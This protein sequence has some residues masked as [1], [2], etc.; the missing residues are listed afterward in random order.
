MYSD[1][2]LL[3]AYMTLNWSFAVCVICKY[4][5]RVK[6]IKT[7]YCMRYILDF[8]SEQDQQASDRILVGCLSTFISTVSTV[9]VNLMLQTSLE[10]EAV[11]F[12]AGAS[13][14]DS[15]LSVHGDVKLDMKQ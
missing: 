11:D 12:A 9:Q 5:Y 14:L 7:A 15:S 3:L 10:L 13:F 4:P 2:H 8:L 6:R 1:E